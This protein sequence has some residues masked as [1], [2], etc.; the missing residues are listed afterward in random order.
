VQKPSRIRLRGD[1]ATAKTPKKKKAA[2]REH[3]NERLI[4][5]NRKAR[6]EY[7]VLE[8]LECGIVL[9]GSEVKSLRTGRLS[10]DDAY[11][12]VK[13]NAVW[14]IGCDIQEYTHANR[15]NHEP[16]RPRKLLMHRREIKKFANRAFEHGLTLVALK[17]Y[18]K[19][20][21][22]KVLMGLCKGRKLYDKR[23]VMKKASM[24][25]DIQRAMRRG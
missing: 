23:E 3:D 15:L 11:G 22:A 4:A 13:G 20:G 6:R 21:R 25:R 14:L 2:D 17:M 12:R 1:S 19:E 5:Q 10:L 16:K 9:V 18:F 7:E 8:T 24:K